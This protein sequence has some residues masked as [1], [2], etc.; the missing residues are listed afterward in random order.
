MYVYKLKK[1]NY[2]K[3][4]NKDKNNKSVTFIDKLILIKNEKEKDTWSQLNMDKRRT[5]N[6]LVGYNICII[7]NNTSAINIYFL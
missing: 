2:K 5:E 4:R 7:L 3:W 6:I 1:N